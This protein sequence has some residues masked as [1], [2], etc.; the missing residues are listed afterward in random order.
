MKKNALFI[1]I[2]GLDGSG[3]TTASKRLAEL[4]E[5]AFPGCI[6]RTFEP[7]DDCC[8]GLFI[9]QCLRKEITDFHPKMLA[10]A[11]A[12]NRLDH[13]QRVVSPWLD[14]AENDGLR[15]VICDRFYLSSLVYQSSERYSMETIFELNDG[16]RRPDLTFFIDV[17]EEVCYQRLAIR[18]QPREL[19]EEKLGQTREKYRAAMVFLKSKTGGEIVEID[20]GGSPEEVAQNLFF[21]IRTRLSI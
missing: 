18:N 6:R 11:Y 21:E 13:C 1:V 19:F 15:L 5:E 17:S 7:E 16:A 12:A 2:E 4:L 9:R 20:G 3:K 10:L 8:A 14:G